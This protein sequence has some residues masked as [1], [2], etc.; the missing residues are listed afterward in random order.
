MRESE[1][2]IAIL[3]E[4]REIQT[5]F[6]IRDLAEPKLGQPDEQSLTRLEG[7]TDVDRLVRIHRRASK[8]ANS[9]RDLLDTP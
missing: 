9:W 2:F 3:D 7:I 4:G 6:L 1:T 5:R 8:E